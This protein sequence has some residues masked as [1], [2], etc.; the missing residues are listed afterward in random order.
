MVGVGEGY[1]MMKGGWCTMYT[2]SQE[3]RRMWHCVAK[4]SR[5][6]WYIMP[7]WGVW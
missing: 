1:M 5:G 4:S 2:M 6:L 7:V 3:I